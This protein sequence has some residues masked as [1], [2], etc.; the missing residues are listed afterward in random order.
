MVEKLGEIFR[1]SSLNDSMEKIKNS[2]RFIAALFHRWQNAG[3]KKAGET[4][5]HRKKL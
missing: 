3:E 5:S 2:Q 4:N 1:T